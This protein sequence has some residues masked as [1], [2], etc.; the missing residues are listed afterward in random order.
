MRKFIID[1][2]TAADDAVALLLALREPNISILGITTVCGNVPLDLAT[3]NA[4]T[5]VETAGKNVPVYMGAQ[6]PLK[7]ELYTAE[8]VHGLDGLGDANLV[9]PKTFP[10]KGDA[11]GFILETIKN[12]PDEIEIIALGPA[13]NI[14]TAILRDGDTMKKVKRIWSMGT[15]GRGKGNV[16]EYAEFNVYVDAESYD[17]MLK[18]G[19]PITIIGLDM[20]LGDSSLNKDE[21][22]RLT[23]FSP[24]GEFIY[25]ATGKIVEHNLRKFSSHT[26]DIPDAVAVAATL[27]DETVISQKDF[28]CVCETENDKTYGGVTLLDTSPKNA[29]VI[30]EFDSKLFKETLFRN[31]K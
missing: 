11:I 5:V 4:L 22:N 24:L 29:T 10:Q 2:D 31:V 15:A 23:S 26:A 25:K 28:Y 14:A 21:L 18:S 1:T 7:R 16:T 20:C 3:K 6:K 8:Y 9:N 12:H 19:I 13:T 17:I 27:W 30:T